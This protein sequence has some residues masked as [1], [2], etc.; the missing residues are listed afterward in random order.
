MYSVLYIHILQSISVYD[1]LPPKSNVFSVY[2]APTTY[3][4]PIGVSCI[5]IPC[6]L[7]GEYKRFGTKYCFILGGTTRLDGDMLCVRLICLDQLKTP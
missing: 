5:V 6:S 1:P 2:P 3:I 4:F 7:V